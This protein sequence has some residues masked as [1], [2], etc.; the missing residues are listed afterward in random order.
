MHRSALILILLGLVAV[1]GTL[2]ASASDPT[3]AFDRIAGH[4]EIIRQALLHDGVDGVPT[5]AREVQDETEALEGE[6]RDAAKGAV[7]G[8]HGELRDLLPEIR[9]ASRELQAPG[10]LEQ[11]R[12][13][14]GSLSKA[15][16]RYRRLI[17][18]PEPVVVFCSMAQE[19]WL[20]P[21]GE[22]GNPYYGQSMARCG[23]IVSQ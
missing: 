21:K 22:I 8:K 16:V 10:G 17:A 2:D 20:Q 4:Y 14:F 11:A 23:E 15:M 9:S 3:A 12:A 18:D 5:A 13:A 1:T 19:V 7:E 6:L